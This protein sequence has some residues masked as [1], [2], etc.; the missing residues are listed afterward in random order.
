[1][2]EKYVW[3]KKRNRKHARI[4]IMRDDVSTYKPFDC[5]KNVLRSA[6]HNDEEVLMKG[7]RF[8]VNNI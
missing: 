2:N 4:R 7:M 8:D 1:M 6:C 3:W 5:K